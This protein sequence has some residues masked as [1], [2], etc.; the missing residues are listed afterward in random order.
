M[1]TS[2]VAVEIMKRRWTILMVK[3]AEFPERLADM[4]E[5]LRHQGC[6]QDIWYEPLARQSCKYLRW[7]NLG[8]VYL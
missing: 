7:D 2:T 3:R 6:R 4:Q 8:E 5:K 1:V